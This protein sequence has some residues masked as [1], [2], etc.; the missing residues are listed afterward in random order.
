MPPPPFP[1][2]SPTRLL[3]GPCSGRRQRADALRDLHPVEQ[4]LPAPSPRASPS[5]CCPHRAADRRPTWWSPDPGPRWQRSGSGH[6]HHR[7]H[8]RNRRPECH[9]QRRENRYH[10]PGPRCPSRSGPSPPALP[11]RP[12]SRSP[13]PWAL[14]ARRQ[15]H[16]IRHVT[17]VGL[18][19]AARVLHCRR[20]TGLQTMTNS[21]NLLTN[22]RRSRHPLLWR[23]GAGGQAFGHVR[24][25]DLSASAGEDHH[26]QRDHHQ[27]G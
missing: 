7:Q 14:P 17:R 1:A 19:A 15:S 20:L 21:R 2:R 22:H 6:A 13:A 26:L 18:S 11:R 23:R 5:T 4:Q 27:S 25:L 10:L 9:T 3:P 16:P 8:R 12:P 24:S